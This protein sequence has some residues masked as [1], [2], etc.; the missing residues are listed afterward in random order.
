MG[1]LVAVWYETIG[2]FDVRILG[3]TQGHLALNFC[4]VEAS[5]TFL[6][7][8]GL[9][10]VSIT[11]VPGP[12]NYISHSCISDPSLSSVKKPASFSLSCC[13]F[14]T[15]SITSIVR[16]S[17]SKAENFF[18]IYTGR[19]KSLLLLFIAKTID[20]IHSNTVMYKQ[21]R[22]GGSI[23]LCNFVDT[24]TSFESV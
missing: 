11:C 6:H 12:N 4:R 20:D 17:E 24:C 18:E 22:G 10:S 13:C 21:E 15:G 19:Q 5:R 23:S 9:N 2:Q 7:N 3:H 1:E 14:Q 8:K 16:L